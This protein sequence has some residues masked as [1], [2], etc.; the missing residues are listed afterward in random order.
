MVIGVACVRLSCL[1]GV[2]VMEVYVGCAYR[3]GFIG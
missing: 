3:V 2:F 1:V